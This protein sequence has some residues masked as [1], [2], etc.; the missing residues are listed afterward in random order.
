MIFGKKKK[1]YTAPSPAEWMPAKLSQESLDAFVLKYT[2]SRTGANP[3]PY[4]TKS[5]QQVQFYPGAVVSTPGAG[6]EFRYLLGQTVPFHR[7]TKAED[8]SLAQLAFLMG[9]NGE[10]E[11]WTRDPKVISQF[12]EIGNSLG[13]ILLVNRGAEI[14]FIRYPDIKAIIHK[15][16][17]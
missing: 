2:T 16:G 5:G 13:L 1:E 15:E 8:F 17:Q 6:K 11:I 10:T 9:D 7:T 4:T 3:I 14:E 12:V